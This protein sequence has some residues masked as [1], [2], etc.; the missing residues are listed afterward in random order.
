[1]FSLQEIRIPNLKWK[2]LLDLNCSYQCELQT[3]MYFQICSPLKKKKK[4]IRAF[5]EMAG[6]R[7]GSGKYK[8]RL[9][10]LFPEA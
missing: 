1:M 10:H 4:K 5:S 2:K 3:Y 7:K 8:V 9:G 6:S